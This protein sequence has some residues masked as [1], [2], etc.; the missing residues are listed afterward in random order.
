MHV[1]DLFDTITN[2]LIADVEAGAGTWQM[3]WRTLADTGTPESVDGRR[4][5]GTNALWLALVGAN[6]SWTS[7]VW[8]TYR[9]WQRHGGQ[10]RRGEKATPVLLWKEFSPKDRHNPTDVD[11]DD[12]DGR[13][14]GKR[15]FAKAYSVFGAEQVDGADELL[16]RGAER[17]ADRDSVERIAAADAYFAGFDVEVIEGGNRACYQP[18][19]DTIRIPTIDRFG[20]PGLLLRHP[21][22]RDGP[23]HGALHPAG[24]DVRAALR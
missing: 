11:D 17:V 20:N 10:V 14:P 23:R 24:P 1:Q 18:A 8:A 13:P 16:T 12:G 19:T 7:G 6:R 5:R 21:G 15:L 22:T 9:G 4:Y 2:Q 3:P